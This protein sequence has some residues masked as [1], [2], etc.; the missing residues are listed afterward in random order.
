MKKIS[1]L[2]GVDFIGHNLAIRLKSIGFVK[3]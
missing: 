3:L 2:G 1:I